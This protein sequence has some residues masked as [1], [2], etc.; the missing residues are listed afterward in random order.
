MFRLGR[1][2]PVS[3]DVITT[4]RKKQ[5]FFLSERMCTLERSTKADIEFVTL[6]QFVD[7]EVLRALH[8][9]RTVL[10][11]EQQQAFMELLTRV[12]VLRARNLFKFQVK[13]VKFFVILEE[14]CDENHY[15]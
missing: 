7:V 2:L 15:F 8:R 1:A 6:A 11:C 5:V 10:K 4:R 12:S 3:T 14:Y 13:S 9:S